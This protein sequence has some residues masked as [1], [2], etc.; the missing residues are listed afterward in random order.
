MKNSSAFSATSQR[1]AM[2]VPHLSRTTT[3]R[4]IL[5]IPTTTFK[6]VSARRSF[7]LALCLSVFV[8]VCFESE[9]DAECGRVVEKVEICFRSCKNNNE[10]RVVCLMNNQNLSLEISLLLPPNLTTKKKLSSLA[11]FISQFIFCLI[12]SIILCKLVVNKRRSRT[13]DDD[14]DDEQRQR[15]EQQPPSRQTTTT[16]AAKWCHHHEEKEM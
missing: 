9:S 1:R 13:D 2:A 8:F 11:Q 5:K 15:L 7:L 14:D 10:K 3:R 6:V 12:H 4:L 16:T